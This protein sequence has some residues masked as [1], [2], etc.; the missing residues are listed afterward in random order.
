MIRRE[1]QHP[2]PRA[3]VPIQKAQ[4]F[5]ELLVGAVGHVFDLQTVRP[6]VVA[7]VIVRR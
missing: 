4:K 7:D 6:E 1:G 3:D 2:L 5:A